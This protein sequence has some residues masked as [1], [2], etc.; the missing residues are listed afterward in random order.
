MWN[1]VVTHTRQSPF[2]GGLAHSCLKFPAS[3]RHQLWFSFNGLGPLLPQPPEAPCGTS[4]YEHVG[5][6]HILCLLHLIQGR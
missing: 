4:V 5:A 3:M 1:F 6:G 2:S